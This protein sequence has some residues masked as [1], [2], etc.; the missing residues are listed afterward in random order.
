MPVLF[1]LANGNYNAGGWTRDVDLIMTDSYATAEMYKSRLNVDVTPI[2]SF[3]DPKEVVAETN[4]RE[5][6]LFVNPSLQK[7][8]LLVVQIAKLLGELR[9]EIKLEIVDSRGAVD[10]VIELVRH[11]LGLSAEYFKNIIK[12][13]MTDDMRTIYQHTRLVLHP[14]LGWDSGPRVLAEAMLNGIPAIITDIGGQPRQIGEAG[15]K[16]KFPETIH[17]PPFN[18]LVP[19][20]WLQEIVEKIIEFYDN[21]ALYQHFV[22]R[23][24]EYGRKEHHIERS[25]DRLIAALETL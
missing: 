16:V 12:T 4:T 11:E 10:E 25:T 19:E 9:P 24:F 20:R 23:A 2:G 22:S 1:Y 21:E 15:I 13:P 5:H 7:G 14:S 18:K 8:A 6:I 3:I 17:E